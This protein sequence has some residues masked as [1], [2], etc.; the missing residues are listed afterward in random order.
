MQTAATLRPD[1][2]VVLMAS[3][4]T[5]RSVNTQSMWSITRPQMERLCTH[6]LSSNCA[7]SHVSIIRM[8][9]LYRVGWTERRIV[10]L[11]KKSVSAC[12]CVNEIAPCQCKLL[13]VHVTS[14]CVVGCPSEKDGKDHAHA[15]IG[16]CFPFPQHC[17]HL[18]LLPDPYCGRALAAN[19]DPLW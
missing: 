3:T 11:G 2:T 6:L 15:W 10:Q 8:L 4:A 18:L 12:V 7:Q 16:L 5:H 14:C 17:S 9:V 13:V 19:H 1:A